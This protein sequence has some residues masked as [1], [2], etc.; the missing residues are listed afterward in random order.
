MNSNSVVSA[1]VGNVHRLATEAT[2]S[3]HALN[4]SM[5]AY[6]S[7]DKQGIEKCARCGLVYYCSKACQKLDWK[8]RH[9]GDCHEIPRH[10]SVSTASANLHQEICARCDNTFK[11]DDLNYYSIFCGTPKLNMFEDFDKNLIREYAPC[12]NKYFCNDCSNGQSTTLLCSDIQHQ[13]DDE[14]FRLESIHQGIE[15]KYAGC[16]LE[17]VLM[18]INEDLYNINKQESHRNS[19]QLAVTHGHP[20]ASLLYL[21]YMTNSGMYTTHPEQCQEMLQEAVSHE[22][23]FAQYMLGCNYFGTGK[24]DK[25]A[26]N[27][28]VN[29]IWKSLLMETLA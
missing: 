10:S 28:V 5:C 15:R 29:Y 13:L 11:Y 9:K 17:K 1:E 24:H 25:A 18:I 7:C 19:L 26:I 2:R 22:H 16:Y 12:C 8:T 21:G 23:P 27:G 3:L 14:G 4:Y 20:L 6:P